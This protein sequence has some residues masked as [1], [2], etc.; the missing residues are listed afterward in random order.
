M[1]SLRSGPGLEPADRTSGRSIAV[2]PAVVLAASYAWRLLVIAAALVASLWLLGKLLVVVV[3]LGVAAL[4]ARALWPVAAR[5]NRAGVRRGLSA[6]LTLLGFLA[7]LAVALGLVGLAV[8]G[9]MDDLGPTLNAGFDDVAEWLVEDSPF[10]VSQR[11]IDRWRDRADE[12]ISSFVRS[13]DD[14]IV[15]GALLAVE[16]SIGAVLALIVTFFILKDGPAFVD[17]ALRVVPTRH[18]P[19]ARRMAERSW[20]AVGGFLRGAA[21]LGVVEALAIGLTLLLVGSSLVAPVMLITFIAAFVPI[22]GA[23]VAGVIAVLVALAT[24]GTVPALIVAG[25]VLVVQQLDNDLLAPVIYGKS[26]Q[27]HPLV[28]LLGIAA[29]GALFGFVGTVF[30]VP[31][32]AAGLSAASELRNYNADP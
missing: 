8:A 24:A 2:H 6:A 27:L 13:N 23:V 17:S 28:I 14:S 12:A 19:V 5:L 26:L 15:S 1:T 22:V 4:L 9:E 16:V 25:V 7:A 20:N 3:P 18:R 29:G 32:L 31:V 11:D 21:L 30:A 10:D